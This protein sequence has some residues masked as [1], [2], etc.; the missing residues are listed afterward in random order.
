MIS[1]NEDKPVINHDDTQ[2]FEG[3]KISDKWKL[4]ENLDNRTTCVQCNK[5]RKYFCYT[6]NIPVEEIK[7]YVPKVE[8]PI[9][10]DIIKHPKEID[11]KS[12]AVHGA[13][14]APDHIT[15]Y[16]YPCMPD[17]PKNGEV[18]LIY[19]AKTSVSVGEFIRNLSKNQKPTDHTDTEPASKR[20]FDNSRGSFKKAVFIDA[21]WTQS[22]R[23][24]KDPRFKNLPCVVL[25]SR[26]T[27]FWRSDK[28]TPRWFLSTIEAVHQFL[29]EL[30]KA[31]LTVDKTTSI[32]TEKSTDNNRLQVSSNEMGAGSEELIDENDTE[33][34]IADE[35]IEYN[36]E[37]DNLL[38]F[39]RFMHHKIH[40]LYEHD[41][42]LSYKRPLS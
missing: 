16:T 1:P 23:I 5:S 28:N 7:E 22:K 25:E 24:Y 6:C 42:L 14:L 35:I 32:V 12:T 17:Y 2:P 36:G 39:F 26:I 37:Y 38:F 3:L 20:K 40:T 19:P 4:L 34:E 11:G 31:G 9:D 8:L 10:I 13:V 18:I 27:Q 21:T 29:I 33:N 15:I 30:H 41:D